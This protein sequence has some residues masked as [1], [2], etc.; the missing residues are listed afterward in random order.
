MGVHILQNRR[1]QTKGRICVPFQHRADC[2]G[3]TPQK[4]RPGRAVILG[5][6][7]S[8]QVVEMVVDCLPMHFVDDRSREV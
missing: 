4:R 5:D 7:A 6:D 2:A 1:A 3:Q 8:W